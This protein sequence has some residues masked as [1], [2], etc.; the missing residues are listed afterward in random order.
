MA[1]NVTV[2]DGAATATVKTTDNTGVHTPHVNIDSIAAGDNNIGNV[3]IAS[4]AAGDNNIGNVDVASSALPTGAS[5]SANQTTII[6]H[7]DGVEA[8]L[9][10]ID[11]DTGTLAVTGGGTETGAL[12]VTIAN[13]S[14]G[15]VSID[16]NGGSLTVDGTV[17]VTGVATAA[18][19]TTMIGHLDGVEG[20][21]TTIDADTGT[22]AA[23]VTSNKV[24]VDVSTSTLPTGAATSAKQD[25]IVTAIE[26]GTV[27]LAS[28][29]SGYI[30]NTD[31]ANTQ[32]IAAGGS[33][34]VTY[35]TDVTITNSSGSDVVVEIK[36]GTTAKWG[37]VIRAGGGFTHRFSSP[38][39]GTAN[40]AWNVDA[41]SATSTLYVGY[42]GFQV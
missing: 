11:G 17:A 2:T 35:L 1:N 22:L 34:V 26:E 42:S 29:V 21:L 8:L 28:L 32:V 27:S 40:T 39:A 25:S 19:Q 4:I 16:D 24:Q 41:A 18:N 36:D 13:N 20:L 12:R 15:V 30:T 23:A 37:A 6:G 3:D 31:G 38:L 10:T 7:L 33:G 14:T 9:T 5:T